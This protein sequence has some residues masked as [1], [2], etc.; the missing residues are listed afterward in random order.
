MYDF[1]VKFIFRVFGALAEYDS[2]FT[3]SYRGIDDN[4]FILYFEVYDDEKDI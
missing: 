3:Y 1:L 2:R 4:H